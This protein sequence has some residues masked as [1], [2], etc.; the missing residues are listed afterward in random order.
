MKKTLILSALLSSAL[1]FGDTA[2]EYTWQGG[3]SGTFDTPSNWDNGL[4]AS[5]MHANHS[6]ETAELSFIIGDNVAVDGSGKSIYLNNSTF[7]LGANSSLTTTWD[8]KIG[9]L[10]ISQGSSIS[11]GAGLEIGALQV[12]SDITN[13]DHDFVSHLLEEA[14]IE[15]GESGKLTFTKNSS[16]GLW[17][18]LGNPNR[19][20]TLSAEITLPISSDFE[21][22]TRDL[23]VGFDIGY[24]DGS[25]SIFDYAH[26]T[27]TESTGITLRQADFV[28]SE[29]AAWV[30]DGQTYTIDQLPYL[31]GV[32]RFVATKEKGIFIQY[33]APEPATVTLSLLALAGLAARRRRH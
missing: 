1:A 20:I 22:M 29:S 10:E 17:T 14:N 6:F 19:A 28:Q 24:R 8:F 21:I 27:V 31:G 3:A 5:S 11:G 30:I 12:D 2:T 16:N 13:A 33:A 32:Y 18:D 4:P 23:L 9:R 25:S 26:S 7:R 15:F